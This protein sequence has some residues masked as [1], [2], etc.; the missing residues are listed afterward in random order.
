[1]IVVGGDAVD[2]TASAVM[3]DGSLVDDFKLSSYCSG[4]YIILFFYPL[5]FSFVCPT[6][7]IAFNNRLNEFHK[8]G[9]EVIGVSVDS[10]FSHMFWRQTQTSQGGIGNINF[11]LVSDLSKFI[12]RSYGVL[13][14][15]TVSFRATF[16]IDRDFRVQ[17]S[18]INNLPLGRNVDEFLRLV[19]AL[20]HVEAHGEVCPANWSEGKDSLIPTHEGIADYL[21]ANAEDM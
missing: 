15:E 14:D 17:H 10:K 2:F 11:P 13:K 19:K 1:M 3:S 8:V 16:L 18:Y 21:V 20:K 5:D 7:I 12:S 9:A 4:K 6:E